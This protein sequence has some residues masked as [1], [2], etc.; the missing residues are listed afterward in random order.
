MPNLTLKLGDKSINLNKASDLLKLADPSQGSIA[1]NIS[2]TTL[3]AQSD[4]HL[5]DLTDTKLSVGFGVEKD[6]KW[7]LS[8]VN[9]TFGF[10]AATEG[11][12]I[13]RKQ[14]VLLSYQLG[15][16]NQDVEIVKVPEG[17]AY[18]SVEMLV[19]LEVEGDAKFSHGNLGIS[20]EASKNRKFVIANHKCISLDTP[21]GEALREALERFELPF[22]TKGVEALDDNDYLEYEFI[23]NLALG[24]GLKYGVRGVFLGG[25]SNGE[26]KRSFES[27]LG[28]A[29][30]KARPSF[31]AQTS[32]SV[33]YQYE[34]AFRIIVGRHKRPADVNTV[35]LFLFRMDQSKLEAQFSAEISISGDASA[36]FD[37]ELKKIIDAA[38]KKLTEGLGVDARDEAIDAFKKALKTQENRRQLEKYVKEADA[39]VNKLL[40]KLDNKK[41]ELAV[42]HERIKKDTALFNYEFDFNQSAASDNGYSLAIKGEFAKAIKVDGVNLLPGSFVENELIRRTTI[43]FQLFDLFQFASITEYFE[44]S[45]MVYAGQ[46]VFRLRFDT[47]VRHESGRV[48]HTRQVE[49][50]YTADALTKDFKSV[51]D[52]DV[53][54]H[55]I[56]NDH[57]NRKA[58]RQT[59]QALKLMAG[60]S[61]LGAAFGPSYGSDRERSY[62]RREGLLCI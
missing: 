27:P 42:L 40:K 51:V 25:R 33:D 38:A 29:V 2:D 10:E 30:V 13:I 45:T 52:L 14:G 56:L 61:D 50:F 26:I 4:K 39:R 55:F 32:F 20:T 58:A 17:Y 8:E 6:A 11:A 54:M 22:K 48:G 43:S 62:P 5:R 16:D 31:Q 1:F 41:V 53:K 59:T 18:V 36:R 46:G 47:G 3:A 23:G 35:T 44:K 60:R 9:V 21:V 19:S 15:Q 49:V 7:K 34:D 12:L 24:F 37:L 57:D 28:K